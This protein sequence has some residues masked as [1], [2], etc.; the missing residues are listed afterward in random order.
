MKKLYD[1]EKWNDKDLFDIWIKLQQEF[2]ARGL[3]TSVGDIGEKLAIDYFNSTPGL[4]NL[5]IAAKGAKNVDALSRDGER[6]SIKTQLKAKKTGAIYTDQENP[7]KQL[8]EFLLVVKLSSD[9]KLES[10]YRFSWEAFIK[11][12]AWDK[13]MT[14]WY[15]PISKNKLSFGDRLFPV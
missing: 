14:A 6:Y 7:I 12:R 11:A 10:L 8:F 13:R 2:F 9:Y 15:I 1:F 3:S 4:S 5:I